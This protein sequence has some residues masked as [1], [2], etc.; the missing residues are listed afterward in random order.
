M[1]TACLLLATCVCSFA[2]PPVKIVLVAGRPSH[3]PGEH[4]HNAGVLLLEKCLRQ[5]QGVECAVV[6]NGWPEDESVLSGA[7]AV[8]LFMGGGVRHPILAADRLATAGALMQKGVG[9]ACL[10]YAVEVPREKAG[11]QFLDWIGAYYER[12][13]SQNPINDVDVTQ[14]SPAHPISR[15]WKSFHCKDEWYYRMRFRPGD[16]R[17]T[18]ILTAVLGGHT[19]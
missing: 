14:A 18:P 13:Y 5:T 17:V 6:K 7:R 16:K 1:K 3:D 9:L 4:E 10:H 12:P 8:V 2:A 11:P 15:G 19:K